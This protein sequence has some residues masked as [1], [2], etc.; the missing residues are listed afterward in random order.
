ML[1]KAHGRA[2]CHSSFF[3]SKK[4]ASKKKYKSGQGVPASGHFDLTIITLACELYEPAEHS[5]RKFPIYILGHLIIKSN[6]DGTQYI[7]NLR[8]GVLAILGQRVL[9]SFDDKLIASPRRSVAGSLVADLLS[10]H[11]N[12]WPYLKLYLYLWRRC[13]P[14]KGVCKKEIYI[15]NGRTFFMC[16][17]QCV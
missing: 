14:S 1:F 17:L 12:S 3:D 6:W 8:Q 2:C 5:I 10:L 15:D 7:H 11:Y 16:H 9:K 13:E 4:T